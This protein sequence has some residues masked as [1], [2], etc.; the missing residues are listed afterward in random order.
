MSIENEGFV[1]KDPLVR[2]EEIKALIKQYIPQVDLS[3]GEF[4]Y[5][6][7]KVAALREEDMQILMQQLVD[8]LSLGTAYG[9]CLIALA[10]GVGVYS[11]FGEKAIGNLLV[12]KT[13]DGI[14]TDIP[15]YTMFSTEDGRQYLS[16]STVSVLYS[17]PVTRS[18]S[19]LTD[20]IP[21]AYQING[22]DWINSL[23]NREGT[24]HTGYTYSN[25]TVTWDDGAGTP[26]DNNIYFVRPTGGVITMVIPVRAASFGAAWNCSSDVVMTCDS[27]S[28][29]EAVVG[30]AGLIGGAD[31]ESDDVLK[32][33]AAEGK[34]RNRT[35]G[36]L[37]SLLQ[38]LDGVDEV[39]IQEIEGNDVSLP[40]TWTAEDVPTCTIASLTSL[41]DIRQKFSP[42]T[43]VA[44]IRSVDLWMSKPTTTY[45][46]GVDVYLYDANEEELDHTTIT[47][48]DFDYAKGTDLQLV[49]APLRSA[50]L[51]STTDYWIGVSKSAVAWGVGIALSLSAGNGLLEVAGKKQVD[52][53]LVMRTKYLANS[54][55][56]QVLPVDGYD[57]TDVGLSIETI[58]NDDYGGFSIYGIEHNIKEINTNY[59]RVAATVFAKKNYSW[60]SVTDAISTAIGVYVDSL[61]IGEPVI[62]NSIIGAIMS[63]AGVT[64][65]TSVIIYKDNVATS[66]STTE[67]A[68]NI[69]KNYKAVQDT[70]LVTLTHG[71]A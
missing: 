62:Y 61:R 7:I 33:R 37:K 64:N 71:N 28:T 25:G 5:Q 39:A 22:I 46:G 60:T 45:R 36:S 32:A 13:V 29:L 12:T 18:P 55:D 42:G 48:T 54:Y 20:T 70:P 65:V 44:S 47:D 26:P 2:M 50:P 1:R 40:S 53:D 14:S 21:V 6:L 52:G 8:N 59:I 68:V 35:T 11:S 15:V 69:A 19:S 30:T 31:L 58:L 56:I 41:Y 23:S 67:Y 4:L 49:N 9:E 34:Y 63:I 51:Y 16:S 43:G 10:A 27:D 38:N 24:E 66:N 17:I 3:E 57:F